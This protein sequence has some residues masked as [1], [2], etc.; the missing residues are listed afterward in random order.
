M[1]TFF[2]IL[3]WLALNISKLFYITVIK[4]KALTYVSIYAYIYLLLSESKTDKI[5]IK[6]TALLIVEIVA[7]GSNYA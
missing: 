7:I 5:I 3:I 1:Q 4:K 2:I 6:V